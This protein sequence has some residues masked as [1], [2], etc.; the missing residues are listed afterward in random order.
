M[1][2]SAPVVDLGRRRYACRTYQPAPSYPYQALVLK[3]WLWDAS[4]VASAPARAAAEP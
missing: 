3:P 2:Y 1:T 4:E